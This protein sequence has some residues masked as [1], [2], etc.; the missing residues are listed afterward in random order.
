MTW[1]GVNRRR[2]PRVH[3]SCVVK[4]RR[5]GDSQSFNTRTE[6]VGCGGV[7]VILPKDIGMFTPVEVELDLTD[8][9]RKINCDG[10]TVWIVGTN[11]GNT[12]TFDTGIEFANLTEEDRKIIDEVVEECLKESTY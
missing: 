11:I 1:E 7:C 8:A 4:I 10:R 3:Y 5:K 12:T 9:K 6:N 2:F